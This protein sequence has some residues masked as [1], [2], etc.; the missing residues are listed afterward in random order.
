MKAVVPPAPMGLV[1]GPGVR[2]KMSMCTSLI[3]SQK[4]GGMMQGPQLSPGSTTGVGATRCTR[5]GVVSRDGMSRAVTSAADSATRST[6]VSR[7]V[8]SGVSF[9]PSGSDDMVER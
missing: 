5:T 9:A 3:R 7:G 8:T 2:R 1:S 6:W 4:R